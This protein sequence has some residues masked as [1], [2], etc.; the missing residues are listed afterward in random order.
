M[1]ILFNLTLRKIHQSLLLS[2]Y[3]NK[4]WPQPHKIWRFITL[5][6]DCAPTIT[7]VIYTLNQ[8]EDTR[9]PK[10]KKIDASESIFTNISLY[11]S[12][13]TNSCMIYWTKTRLFSDSISLFQYNNLHLSS[14]FTP[15][16]TC[17]TQFITQV[18]G[19]YLWPNPLPPNIAQNE[20]GQ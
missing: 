14:I 9:S 8:L 2:F 11:L 15:L 17:V 5:I 16:K 6:C 7:P 3:E 10:C 18:E 1:T 12:D 4:T 20:A 19:I 13:K